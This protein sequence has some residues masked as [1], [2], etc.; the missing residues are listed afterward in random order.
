VIT[1][2]NGVQIT[3]GGGLN[4][5]GGAGIITATSAIVGSAVTINNTGIN[6]TG[7]I[8]ASSNIKIGT[9]SVATNGKA[10]AMAMVFGG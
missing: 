4:I 3:G 7:I 10:I 5:T 1:A 8:T 2:R 9:N 6:V